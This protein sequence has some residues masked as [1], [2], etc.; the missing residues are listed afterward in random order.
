MF[1]HSIFEFCSE[2]SFK[3]DQDS[4]GAVSQNTTP[5]PT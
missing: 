5:P 2:F 1:S 4:I 3:V